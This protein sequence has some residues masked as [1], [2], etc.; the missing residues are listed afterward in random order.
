MSEP[1]ALQ[2]VLN[3]S[4]FR[5]VQITPSLELCE[6]FMRTECANAT[7]HVFGMQRWMK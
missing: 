4:S 1:R 3:P 5:N 2:V 6:I 7:G